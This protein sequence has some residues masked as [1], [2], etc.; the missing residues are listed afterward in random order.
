MLTY[1]E[2]VLRFV[3]EYHED[4]PAQ[5]KAEMRINGMDPDNHWNLQWSFET[6]DR[7]ED[8]ARA[9]EEQ[10]IEFCRSYGYTPRK[11]WRVRDLGQSIKI[12][13]SAFL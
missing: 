2:T 3:V 11:K 8:Q 5:H 13:R 7:A 9:E 4:L 6:R 10:H 1:T 12:E